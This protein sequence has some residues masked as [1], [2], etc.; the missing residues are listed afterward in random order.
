MRNTE[1]PDVGIFDV[2]A[3]VWRGI[4]PQRW[5]FWGILAAFLAGNLAD[6]VIPLF[7]KDFF[8]TVAG[9]E[10][11]SVVVPALIGIVGI[12]FAL[13][14]GKWFMFRLGLWGS[15]YVQVFG[16]ARLREQSFDYLIRH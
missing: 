14:A 2:L 5:L 4:R 10:N 15:N 11:P 13:N 9:A 1:Y 16:M 7:Y 3:A 8:D 6:I 12:I